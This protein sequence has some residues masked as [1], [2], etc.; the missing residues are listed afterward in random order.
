MITQKHI[1]KNENPEY[2]E[3][4]ALEINNPTIGSRLEACITIKAAVWDID[5]LLQLYPREGQNNYS[6]DISIND[7]NKHIAFNDMWIGN[8]RWSADD[9]WPLFENALMCTTYQDKASWKSKDED[10]GTHTWDLLSDEQKA[11]I[12]DPLRD[13]LYSLCTDEE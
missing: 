6:F 1:V 2:N 7:K 10:D 13:D 9:Y 4:V 11:F 8:I 12:N 5:I 3:T